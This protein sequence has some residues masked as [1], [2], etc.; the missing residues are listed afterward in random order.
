MA[1]IGCTIN[2][3]FS[4]SKSHH[5]LAFHTLAPFSYYHHIFPPFLSPFLPPAVCLGCML[6][7]FL[8]LPTFFP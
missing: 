2:L 7:Y 3:T 4:P 1:K 6:L 8:I 5:L